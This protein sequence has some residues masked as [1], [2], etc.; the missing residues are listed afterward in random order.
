MD[1]KKSINPMIAVGAVVVA[2]GLLI[3][4]V[5][6]FSSPGYEPSPGLPGAKAGAGKPSNDG[7]VG[8]NGQKGP[9]GGAFYPTGPKD[10]MPGQVSGPPIVSGSANSGR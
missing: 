6:R 10:R 3:F 5:M 1:E 9:G 8:P 4:V 2:V 7:Q